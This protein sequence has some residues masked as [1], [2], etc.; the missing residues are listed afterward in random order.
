MTHAVGKEDVRARARE[1]RDSVKAEAPALSRLM[2]QVFL[3]SVLL[4][5]SA[6]VSAYVAIR[7]EADPS[8]LIDALR[9]RGHVLVLPRVSARDRPLDF[10]LY[11]PGAALVPGGFG[12]SEPDASWP[13]LDPDILLVPLLAFDATGTRIGYGGGYYDRT[14]ASLRA[15]GRPVLAVGYGFAIQEFPTLARDA[16]DQRLD[17][18][19][20]ETSARRFER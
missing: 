6:V 9:A 3:D 14:L 16:H 11:R 13:R 2:A 12:L 10:H 18:I 7:G 5:A 8:F 19:V 17:W 4:P 15:R 20:T 1:R